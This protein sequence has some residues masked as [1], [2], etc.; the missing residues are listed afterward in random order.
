[1]AEGWH[2]IDAIFQAALERDPADRVAFLDEACAGDPAVRA[3]VEALL[4]SD[5]QTQSFIESPA[6]EMV[7]RA[8]AAER[9]FT[10]NLQGE[11]RLQSK[12]FWDRVV[13]SQQ[14]TTV[15]PLPDDDSQSL[16]GRVIGHY[17]IERLIPGGGMGRVY[18][19]HDTRLGGPVALKL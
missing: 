12:E 9:V 5:E 1:M 11:D 10:M 13:T 3:K 15:S 16:I 17:R 2:K 7:A 19:A 8:K 6:L 4:A 14:S 18:I